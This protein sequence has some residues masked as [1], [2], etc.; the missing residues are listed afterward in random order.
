MSADASRTKIEEFRKSWG[1]RAVQSGKI[2]PRFYHTYES[3]LKMPI[4]TI[5][6]EAT[7]NATV[8]NFANTIK[9][10]YLNAQYSGN[11]EQL[12]KA[13]DDNKPTYRDP[14]PAASAPTPAP[15]PAPAPSPS[16]AECLPNGSLTLSLNQY[17]STCANI[18]QVN[19]V[20]NK[21]FTTEPNASINF[22][23]EFETLQA[24]AQADIQDIDGLLS[25]TTQ[26][27]VFTQII[28]RLRAQKE[29]LTHTLA[30]KE[31]KAAAANQQFLDDRT[32]AGE[33]TKSK[34]NVLQDYILAAFTISW[35]FLIVVLVIYITK[36]SETPTRSLISG[37]I[38]GIIVSAVL[39]TWVMAIA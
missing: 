27:G 16:N 11:L 22:K 12:A 9:T 3:I 5:N 6:D 37:S 32:S 26:S 18:P 29:Q 35:I 1:D 25:G 34:V 13:I 36:T 38:L 31:A 14:V 23:K 21:F 17:Q 33:V 7:F 39:Y 10:W 24:L 20:R 4:P 28:D 8:D 19:E 2:N 30:E 15:T